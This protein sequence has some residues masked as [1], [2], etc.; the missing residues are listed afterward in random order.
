MC[1]KYL[2]FQFSHKLRLSIYYFICI[3]NVLNFFHM[4]DAYILF[5]SSLTILYFILMVTFKFSFHK[6]AAYICLGWS[7]SRGTWGRVSGRWKLTWSPHINCIPW[8]EAV[9]AKRQETLFFTH[10]HCPLKR[11]TFFQL[12]PKDLNKSSQLSGCDSVR[13]L[14]RGSGGFPEEVTGHMN[15]E[16]EG[17]NAKSFSHVNSLEPHGL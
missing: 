16:G 9:C 14:S 6:S 10:G 12:T 8:C 2:I 3:S 5:K 4:D 17:E 15:N 11:V 13:L 1:L 7:L